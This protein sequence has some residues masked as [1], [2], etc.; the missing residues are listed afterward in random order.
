M[1]VRLVVHEGGGHCIKKSETAAL[2]M[3]KSH[4]SA[5]GEDGRV[6]SIDVEYNLPGESEFQ[7]TTMPIHKLV[8]VVPAEEQEFMGD[9][10]FNVGMRTQRIGK[11]RPT[12][13]EMWTKA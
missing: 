8:M 7:S 9:E 2:Q 3:C 12:H 1:E 6:H 10:D 13:L 4:Q 11:M 5:K